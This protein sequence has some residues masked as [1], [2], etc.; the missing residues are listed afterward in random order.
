[1]EWERLFVSIVKEE[2]LSSFNF[3]LQADIIDFIRL[4]KKLFENSF[5][6]SYVL[7]LKNT[8][9]V[10]VIFAKQFVSNK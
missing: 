1:M 9:K 5:D 3:C 2:I 4:A 6:M 10:V 8:Y 7:V